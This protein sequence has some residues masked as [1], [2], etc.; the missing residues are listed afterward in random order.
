MRV[1]V[2]LHILTMF[3]AVAMGYGSILFVRVA[4]R[5]RQVDT[6]RGVL[7]AANRIG[8]FIGPAFGI[9]IL[10]GIVAIF[11]NRFNPLAPWLVIAYVLA[12]TAI[13]SSVVVLQPW[14]NRM[15]AA[16]EGAT[17]T[18]AA[19]AILADSRTQLLLGL[20]TLVM[21]AIIADMVLKPFS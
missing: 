11:A 19:N 1:F 15:N 12:A 17:D 14:L 3:T 21:V 7:A 13:L 6:L 20:D 16:V 2:F 18:S 8:P 9:G 10:L 5:T 4:A